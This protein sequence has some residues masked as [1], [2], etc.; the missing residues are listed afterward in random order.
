MTQ[1]DV[2]L[3]FEQ[4]WVQAYRLGSMCAMHVIRLSGEEISRRLNVTF[5]GPGDAYKSGKVKEIYP[6]L[7]KRQMACIMGGN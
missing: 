5:A 1:E 7:E 4:L 6:A 2:A 3:M